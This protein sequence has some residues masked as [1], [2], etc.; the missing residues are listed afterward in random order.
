MT[1]MDIRVLLKGFQMVMEAIRVGSSTST[2]P[3]RCLRGSSP[4]ITLI[5]KYL[6]I[7]EESCMDHSLDQLMVLSTRSNFQDPQS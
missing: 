1:N 2:T 6:M 4:T 3:L 5:M 7:K